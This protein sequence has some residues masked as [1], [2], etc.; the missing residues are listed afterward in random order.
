MAAQVP[1]CPAAEAL[2]PSLRAA[3]R[4][5]Q[6]RIHLAAAGHPLVGDPLYAPGGQPWPVAAAAGGSRE[7]VSAGVAAHDTCENCVQQ[8]AA[9]AAAAAAA[10][11]AGEQV[12]LAA[13]TGENNRGGAAA[14][15]AAA[16]QA[17]AL[18]GP[19]AAVEEREASGGGGRGG[20]KERPRAVMPGDCGY[21]LHSM[22]L[23]FTHPISG[24]RVVA[25]CEPPPP[26]RLPAPA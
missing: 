17:Q 20:I 9:E 19:P 7:A 8:P 10:A 1:L 15:A 14:G 23:E 24:E 26:L 25:T 22:V 13:A 12:Q 2:L 6:I 3:G 18:D 21:L 5:H 4:P 11:A 16:D